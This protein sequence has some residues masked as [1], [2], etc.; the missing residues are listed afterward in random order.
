MNTVPSPNIPEILST[1]YSPS[2][3]MP[4]PSDSKNKND[5]TEPIS[6]L[7]IKKPKELNSISSSM[8]I[9]FSLD[10]AFEKSRVQA[11]KNTNLF[12]A[13]N[14]IISTT[15]FQAK[16]LKNSEAYIKHFIDKNNKLNQV[17]YCLSILGIIFV[18]LFFMLSIAT[19]TFALMILIYTGNIR[20]AILPSLELGTSLML[21]L[22]SI[23]MT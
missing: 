6:F 21:I 4:N 17:I 11:M 10:F 12:I 8:I 16:V 20:L 2:L 13:V 1:S 7:E 19:F 5:L 22:L 9:D 14:N 23:K 3:S 15:S 18:P